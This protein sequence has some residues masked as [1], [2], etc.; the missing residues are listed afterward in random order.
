MA[1]QRGLPMK[2]RPRMQ[3]PSGRVLQVLSEIL[4]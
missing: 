2:A 3:R 1:K 4:A